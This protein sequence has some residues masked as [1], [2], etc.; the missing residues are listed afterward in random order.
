MKELLT[1]KEVAEQL[2]ISY[3]MAAQLIHDKK[4]KSLKLGG[5]TYRIKYIDLLEFIANNCCE[6]D[7]ETDDDEDET[8]GTQEEVSENVDAN[9]QEKQ[10]NKN[11]IDEYLK[12]YSF[13]KNPKLREFLLA[14]VLKK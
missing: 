4:I 10:D 13:V 1:V 3:R 2:S 5:K 12:K 6:D 8:D 9:K 14:G 7:D 11:N